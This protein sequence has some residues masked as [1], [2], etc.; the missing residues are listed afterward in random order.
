MIDLC[1]HS[2]LPYDIGF[3]QRLFLRCRGQGAPT[4]A[5]RRRVLRRSST[6]FS[7]VFFDTP[8]GINSALWLPLQENL[9]KITT[10]GLL[11]VSSSARRRL[12]SFRFAFTIV[13]VW[14]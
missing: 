6:N 4:G 13:R 9:K 5:F 1:S 10:V 3:G 11:V 7:A 8:T 12:G 2:G 14:R